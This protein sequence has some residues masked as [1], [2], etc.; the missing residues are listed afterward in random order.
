MTQYIHIP[1]AY[2]YVV[3]GVSGATIS[4]I[5]RT[6]GAIITA[7]ETRGVPGELTIEI[8]GSLLQ[9]QAAQEMIKVHTSSHEIIIYEI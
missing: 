3:I 9:V 5:R 6:T 2:A 1:L 7:Q 4:Y 8:N